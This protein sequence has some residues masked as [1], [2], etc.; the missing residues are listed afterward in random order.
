[1]YRWQVLIRLVAD[2]AL[3][4]DFLNDAL[5]DDALKDGYVSVNSVT[6]EPD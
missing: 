1:L 2:G 4:K 5:S 6:I 3:A